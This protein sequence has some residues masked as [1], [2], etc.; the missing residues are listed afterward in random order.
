MN[1]AGMTRAG[2]LA[3]LISASHLMPL[4]QL[5]D[6][7]ASRA[8]RVGWP[9]V[10]IYLADL[11]QEKLY[12]LTARA[13]ADPGDPDAQPSWSVEGTVAGRAFQL[14][15][16]LPASSASQGEWWVPLLDGA[17]RLGVLRVGFPGAQVEMDEDLNVLAGLV[18]LL[19]VSKREASDSYSQLIRRRKMKVAA[20][21]E[22]QLMPPR[23]FATDRVLVSAIMEPA[24]Q[25]SG[26]AFDYALADETLHLSIFDAMGHDTAAGLTVNLAL[27]AARN[28]RRQGA[29]LL[30][31]AEG[32]GETLTKQFEGRRYATSLLA[33]LHLPTGMLTWTNYG[34]HPPFVIRG[35]RAVVHMSC[36]PAPP[37]G[38]GLGLPGTLRRDQLEPG[39]RL[40]LYTDGITEARNQ[41]G[42]E[43]GLDRLI[44]FLVR[45]HADGLP[46]PETLRRLIRHHLDY[47]NGRLN[48][49][50]TVMLVEWHGPTPFRPQ[51]LKALVGLP[52]SAE[53]LSSAE[54]L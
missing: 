14:G 20:E 53:N 11:Q 37:M 18:A 2:A 32:V 43:F 15:R 16:I 21:M 39:D 23:T 8:A 3:E 46:V 38:T 17:E 30:Q 36:P 42:Q 24:Y 34:H 48:D 22:W 12:L 33:E 31:T 6:A 4:E 52:P 47:H 51:Q 35:N 40:L 1:S 5:P 29:E 7:V 10:L 28:R 54:N 9:R 50:A 41:D 44:D 49:D 26:D 19:L 13:G 25:V 45:H 27:A